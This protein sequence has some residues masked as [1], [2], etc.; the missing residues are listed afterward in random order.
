[1]KQLDRYVARHVIGATALALLFLLAL[2]LFISVVEEL[3][4]VGVNNYTVIRS[5]E[6]VA[7]T[8]PSLAF[9]LFPVAG[10]I[11]SLLGLGLLASNS[12]LVVFRA[13]G[14]SIARIVGAVLKA[15]AVLVLVA[16]LIGELLAPHAERLAQ[17]R[18]ALARSG[19]IQLRGAF[20]F[21]VRD[22]TSFINIR[23]L[24]PGNRMGD[25]YIYEFDNASRLRVATYAREAR[26]VDDEWRLEDIR[27]TRI[28]GDE[29]TAQRWKN[30]LWDSL[31]K[32]DLVNL[33][34]VRPESLSA[35]GLYRYIRY[36]RTNGLTTARFE[37]ALWTKI[38]YPVATAV[39][40]LLAVPL[41]LGRLQRVGLGARMLIG[42]MIGVGFHIV[43]QAAGHVGLVYGLMPWVVA[44]APTG[45]FF[46]LGMWMLH[47]VR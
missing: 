34:A 37:L 7:L 1:M 27:Q 26:F 12:E 46:V 32:P 23:R 9:S 28:E 15:A 19:Q 17:E 22:G 10:V 18:R 41:V 42:A 24:V 14:V 40:I 4:R 44:V 11:G 25:I 21:W 38:V 35:F 8:A 5:L 31:F 13:S 45:A 3:G 47:R 20:G 43:N 39:M 33:V 36:L 6:F 2:F 30:A 16:V 29:I